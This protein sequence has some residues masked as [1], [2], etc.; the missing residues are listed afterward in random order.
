MSVEE[1]KVWFR[2]GDQD[3]RNVR[4]DFYAVWFSLIEGVGNLVEDSVVAPGEPTLVQGDKAE[5]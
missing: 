3:T 2:L 4:V 1:Y 5:V